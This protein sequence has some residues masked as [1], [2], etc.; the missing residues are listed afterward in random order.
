MEARHDVGGLEHRER[1]GGDQEPGVIIDHVQDLDPGV[2]GEVPV[3]DVCLPSLVR[4]LCFEPDERAPWPFLR[5]GCDEAPTRQDP[6]DRGDRG[7][8]GLAVT[9]R[10]V[11]R[12]RVGSRIY[13]E[14][15]QFLAQPDDLVFELDRGPSGARP[16]LPRPRFESRLAFGIEAADELV[17]PSRGDPV[18]SRHLSFRPPLDPDRRDHEPRK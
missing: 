11:D 18:V 2:V 17:D 12:D 13:P 6:P 15:E 5:L 16:R 7:D 9:P 3:G 4:H 10:Q 14:V 8:R 1:I